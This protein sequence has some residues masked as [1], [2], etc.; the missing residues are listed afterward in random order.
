VRVVTAC[1]LAVLAASVAACG[2][3]GEAP[4]AAEDPTI[5]TVTRPE[6][7]PTTPGPIAGAPTGLSGT[8]LHV[9]GNMYGTLTDEAGNA[10]GVLDPATGIQL[11]GTPGGSYLSGGDDE[12]G[13]YFIQEGAYEG[14]WTVKED[15]EVL[16]VARNY[17]GDEVVEVAATLPF[18][19]RAG[20]K[21]SLELAAAADLGPLE[22]AVDEGGDGGVDRAVAFGAPVVGKGA[23]DRIQP[24]SQVEVEHVEGA[25][26]KQ[27]ARVTITVNDLG[28]AGVAR[29]EYGVTPSN[30]AGVYMKP[31]ELPAV[32]RIV[33][34]AID[35]AGN[36]EAPY[37]D[38]SLAP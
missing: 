37:P 16:F 28:G 32:G 4:G 23:D 35:R 12:A 20:D 29:I 13:Q 9:R 19:V 15:D 34:R 21:L 11:T 7:V 1:V 3:G 26:G 5:T 33:V 17:A 10:M 6:V 14:A 27:V 31:L 36:I 30:Q 38:A 24:V 2:E 18:V 8:D 25:G 22:L